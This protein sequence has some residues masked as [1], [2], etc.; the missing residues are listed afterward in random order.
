MKNYIKIPRLLIPGEEFSKW[1]VIACDQFSHDRAY[2]ERVAC[3]VGDAP[4][5]LRMVPAPDSDEELDQRVEAA[6][7]AAFSALEEGDLEKI[8]RGVSVVARKIKDGVRCGIVAAFDLDAFTLEE[9]E[10]SPVRPVATADKEEVAV[11]LAYRRRMPVEIP[12]AVVFYKDKKNKIVRS[13][14]NE[15]LEPIYECKLM[16]DG[17]YLKGYFA[18]ESLAEEAVHQMHTRGDPCF[19]VVEGIASVTAAKLYWEELKS[20]LTPRE[21]QI[22]PARYFLAEFINIYEPAVELCPVHRVVSDVETEAFCDFIT[23]SVKCRREGNILYPVSSDA[24]NIKKCDALIGE[25]LRVNGGTLRYAQSEETVKR[26]AL[27]DC[28]GVV[29]CAPGKEEIFSHLKSGALFPKHSFTLGAEREKR[30]YMEARE[31]SYD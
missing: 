11:Q 28:A 17:G 14:F 18:D 29:L 27:E 22:H 19:A 24:E 6:R 8:S 13:L 10:V 1:S 2:W 16:E 3:Y 23:R 30:Y 31:I 4:S 25:F 12:H 26:L 21:Q 15:D 5:T 7:R 20:T 9:G